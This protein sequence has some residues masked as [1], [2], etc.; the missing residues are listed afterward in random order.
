[1]LPDRPGTY[2][3]IL[4]LNR[5]A[6]IG[7]GKLGTFAFAP[8]FYAYVGSALGPGGLRARVR[9]HLRSDKDIHWHVDALRAQAQPLEVWYAVGTERRE[10]AWADALADLPRAEIPAPGFGASDCQC[11]SHLIHIDQPDKVLF[12]Q[13]VQHEIFRE[14]TNGQE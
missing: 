8:G 9:R 12:A 14:R 4:E 13:S 1:M 7:I 6:K 10:C 3:L 5:P 2:V 11:T